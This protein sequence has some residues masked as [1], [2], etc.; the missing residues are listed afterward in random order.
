MARYSTPFLAACAFTVLIYGYLFSTPIFTNHTIPNVWVRDYPTYTTWLEGRWFSDVIMLA[1]GTSGVQPVQMVLAAALQ[2]VNAFLLAAILRVGG[3]LHL[4]LVALFMAAHPAFLDYYSYTLGHLSFVAGDSLALLGVLALDRIPL[5][6]GGAALS[7]LCFVLSLGTYQPKIAL[8][9]TLLLMWCLLGLT[10]PPAGSAPSQDGLAG[11]GRGLR[12][13]VPAVLVAL[14]AGAIYAGSALLIVTLG[15]SNRT[16]LNQPVAMARQVLLSFPET[17]A[18]FTS[19]VQYL[20]HGLRLLPLLVVLLGTVALFHRTPRR[21]WPITALLILLFPVAFQASYVVNDETFA[22]SGR[23]LTA[24]AYF[25]VFFMAAGWSVAA[26]RRLVTAAACVM[27]YFF[28][29]VAMQAVNAAAMI[30]IFDLS[31]I[32]RIV[33]RV[34]SVAPNLY[35]QPRGLV[36]VGNLSYRDRQEFSS[37]GSGPY[38]AGLGSEAF[39][40][41]RQVEIVNFFLGNH[42]LATPTKAQVAAVLAGAATHRPWPAPDSVYLQDGVVVVLLQPY[43]PGIS[44]TWSR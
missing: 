44:V 4:L 42:I 22:T 15:S 12:R 10:R 21:S 19:R 1:T 37:Y 33:S 36:V 3:R 43:A 18:D 9:G 35:D 34:E 38:G 30:T 5:R 39:A 8:I 14:A 31:K 24:H 13:V 32:N 40:S 7:V 11:S 16:H 20:P 27:I 28:A 25:L 41:Y 17:W 26:F 2:I 29:I 23:I 6:K